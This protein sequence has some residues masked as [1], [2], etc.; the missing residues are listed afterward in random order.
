VRAVALVVVLFACFAATASAGTT[1]RVLLPGCG[2]TDVA[3]YKPKGVIVL[4]GDGGFRVV[5]IT[6]STW[7]ETSATGRGTAKVNNC[8]PNCASGKFESFRVKVSLSRPKTC[9]GSKREFARF[10]YS[11]PGD[12]PDGAKRTGTLRRGCSR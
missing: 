4:C 12:K 3:R 8:K 6:W 9:P 1:E 10:T 2:G 11:F 5:R 7:T